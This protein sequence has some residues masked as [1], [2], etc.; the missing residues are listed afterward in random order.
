VRNSPFRAYRSRGWWYEYPEMAHKA[1]ARRIDDLLQMGPLGI[2]DFSSVRYLHARALRAHT[3]AVLSEAE[4]KSFI[5][6]VNSPAYIELLLK[7]ELTGAWL[8]GELVGT[9]G[10]QSTGD[11]GTT[12]R[13]GSL[14]VAHPRMGI[15]RRLLQTFETRASQCGFHHFTTGVTAN[16][17]PFFLRHGYRVVS[18][19]LRQ[20]TPDCG[21]P[22]T[23]LKKT[24]QPPVRHAPP[25]ALM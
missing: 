15:G 7:E 10:W 11:N 20:L 14:F 3:G 13:V 1:A 22:V 16:A 25:S 19:G 5:N 4:V 24:P 21:L 18:R 8:E 12:A 23:F 17:V 2:D 9:V 6:L